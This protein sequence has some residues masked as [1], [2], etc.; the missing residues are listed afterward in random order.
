[1]SH[2]MPITHTI[3]CPGCGR[4]LRVHPNFRLLISFTLEAVLD[5]DHNYERK[6]DE[7]SA[8]VPGMQ[9]G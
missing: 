2:T 4:T 5:C 7:R 1:M 9:G 8:D 3:Q 6:T